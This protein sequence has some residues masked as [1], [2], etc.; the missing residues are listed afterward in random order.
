MKYKGFEIVK[1]CEY[2]VWKNGLHL[3]VDTSLK[4]CKDFLNKNP[5]GF[6]KKE[7]KGDWMSEKFANSLIEYKK[8]KHQA[9]AIRERQALFG[10]VGILLTEATKWL[11]YL[12]LVAF[13]QSQPQPTN[14]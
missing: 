7:A 8:L 4:D 6:R 3:F 5:T 14:D 9:Q 2:H 13:A 10:L 1:V 11:L 12:L